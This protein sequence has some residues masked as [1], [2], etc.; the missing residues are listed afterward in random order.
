MSNEACLL[1][2]CSSAAQVD[3]LNELPG[4]LPNSGSS[5]CMSVYELS[6][7]AKCQKSATR[8]SDATLLTFGLINVTFSLQIQGNYEGN[9]AINWRSKKTIKRFHVSK[10]ESAFCV[11]KVSSA[12]EFYKFPLEPMTLIPFYLDKA[13][14]QK[15]CPTRFSL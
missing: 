10:I 6:K 2:I 14:I 1:C 8:K 12:G 7:N 9:R 11:I 5:E 3:C 13:H 4:S 15:I